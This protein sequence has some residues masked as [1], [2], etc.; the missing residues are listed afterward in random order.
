MWI[1]SMIYVTVC[2]VSGSV[3]S[4]QRAER[5][6]ALYLGQC[7]CVRMCAGIILEFLVLVSAWVTFSLRY[8]D[9]LIQ[10]TRVWQTQAHLN[11][12]PSASCTDLTSYITVVVLIQKS[13]LKSLKCR[14]CCHLTHPAIINLYD[15]HISFVEP[16]RIYSKESCGPNNTGLH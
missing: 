16:K 7:V 11:H 6:V 13:H 5:P 3:M 14:N 4:C 1:L 12:Q 2:H 9:T 10:T 15:F 8:S